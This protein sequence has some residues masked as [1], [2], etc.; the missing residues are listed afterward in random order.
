MTATFF[1]LQETRTPLKT[2]AISIIANIVGSIVL[3][4]PLAHGGLALAVAV[5]SIVN[6][7]LLTK[8]LSTKLGLPGWRSILSSICRTLACSGLA[9]GVVWGVALAI[10]PSG[11][12]SSS[13]L[14]AGL[15]VCI[16]AGLVTYILVSFFIRSPELIGVISEIKNS[17]KKR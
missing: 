9:G 2:A 10:K 12:P 1:A 17:L 11:N 15:A 7:M 13:V 3:I 5:A 6:L 4:G 14:A 16:I 8:A